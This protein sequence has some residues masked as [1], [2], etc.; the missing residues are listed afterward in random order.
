M[1]RPLSLFTRLAGRRTRR[2]SNPAKNR[3][4]L[5][6]EALEDRCVPASIAELA[7]LP[8]AGAA[9]TDL[10]KAPDGSVWFTEKNANKLGRYSLGGVLTEYNVPTAASAPDQ[11]VANSDGNVWFTERNGRKIGRIAQGGGAI[12]EFTLPGVGEYPTAIATRYDGTVWFASNEQPNL[13]RLAKISVAGVITYLP[14]AQT[15]SYISDLV[16]GPDGNLWVT[17]ISTR[18]GDSVAKVSTA[19][20]GTFTHYLLTP[21]SSPQ[22]ITVGPD[23]NLWFTEKNTDTI[24]RLT[25]TGLKTEFALGAGKGPQDISA[26]PGNSLYFTEATG[27][28]IGQITTAGVI[29]QYALPTAGSQPYGIVF[30]PDGNMWFAEQNGNR[31]G[32]LVF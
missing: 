17:I 5:G 6:L 26:G 16:S 24:G 12:A 20:W 9:P 23:N 8:T 32:K 14:T 21:G 18:W 4:R 28:A 31:L 19:G 15:Q 2:P 1:I 29:T 11:I 25:T 3:R 22:S 13:A 30:G 10:T 7:T 27:N